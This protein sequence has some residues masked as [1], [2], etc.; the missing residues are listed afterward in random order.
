MPPTVDRFHCNLVMLVLSR[1]FFNENLNQL[2]VQVIRIEK[3]CHLRTH[4]ISVLL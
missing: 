2:T 1:L 3:N 4:S